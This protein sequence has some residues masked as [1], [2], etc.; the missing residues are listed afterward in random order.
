MYSVFKMRRNSTTVFRQRLGWH[1]PAG[2]MKK[3][4]WHFLQCQVSGYLRMG[5][6]VRW[7]R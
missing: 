1:K 7:F 5:R 3:S 2:F 6:E 4:Q